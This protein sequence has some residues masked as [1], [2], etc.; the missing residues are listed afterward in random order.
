MQA[1]WRYISKDGNIH[2]YHSESLKSY[3][4]QYFSAWTN[5]NQRYV[6]Y[7][8]KYNI[9]ISTIKKL[10]YVINLRSVHL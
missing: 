9:D 8:F 4:N 3:T 2:N 7:H 1:A 5:H 6:P 10:M